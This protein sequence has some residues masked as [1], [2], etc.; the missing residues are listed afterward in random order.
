MLSGVPSASATASPLKFQILHT[1]TLLGMLSMPLLGGQA[2][3]KP[4]PGSGPAPR[5]SSVASPPEGMD[6][7]LLPASAVLTRALWGC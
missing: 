5:S 6:S 7:I 1:K 4:F 3:K 2:R